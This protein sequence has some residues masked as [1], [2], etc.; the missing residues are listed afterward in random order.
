MRKIRSLNYGYYWIAENAGLISV[1]LG[2]T[3]TTPMAFLPSDWPSFLWGAAIGAVAA[4]GTGFLQKAGE[5]AFSRLDGKLNPKTPEP[6]QVDGKFIATVF[7]PGLCAWVREVQLYDYE[8]KGYTYYPHPK[9]EGHCF[10]ITSDGR[11][12]VKEFL[13]VQPGTARV[14]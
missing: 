7:P 5:K 14:Q 4:F 13:M 11:S 10:R 12:P 8:E 6:V 9:T 3:R 1:A 2:I